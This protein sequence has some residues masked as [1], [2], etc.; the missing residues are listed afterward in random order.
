MLASNTAHVTKIP[1]VVLDAKRKR[2]QDEIGVVAGREV[3]IVDEDGPPA[4]DVDYKR[5]KRSFGF[6][7]RNDLEEQRPAMVAGGSTSQNVNVPLDPDFTFVMVHKS[8]R[9]EAINFAFRKYLE[10]QDLAV[11]AVEEPKKEENVEQEKEEPKNAV[12]EKEQQKNE[13]EEGKKG[14]QRRKRKRLDD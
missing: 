8:V 3:I 7:T 6:N 5:R 9:E 12:Q 2:E 14:Q 4:V 11:P 1:S 13:T 10:R